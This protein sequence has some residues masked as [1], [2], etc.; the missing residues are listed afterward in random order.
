MMLK[1]MKNTSLH[2]RKDGY[3]PEVIIQRKIP[4]CLVRDTSDAIMCLLEKYN[5]IKVK[6]I[7][8]TTNKIIYYNKEVG[9]K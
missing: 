2:G 6:R 5:T 4:E 8:K 9:E 1:L 7:D 3:M